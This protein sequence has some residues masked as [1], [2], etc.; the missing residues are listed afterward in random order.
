MVCAADTI[1]CRPDPHSRFSVSAGLLRHAGV[2]RGDAREVHVLRLGMDHVAEHHLPDLVAGDA[3]A[4]Q[5][6]A[7]HLSAEIGGRHVLQAAAEIA[8]RGA[9][10]GNHYHFALRVHFSSPALPDCA[11]CRCR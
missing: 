6:L 2:H 11:M 4:R 10:A 9:H 7:H 3:G 5:C 8:D 1:A